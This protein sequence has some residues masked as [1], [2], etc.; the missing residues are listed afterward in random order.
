M[1]KIRSHTSEHPNFFCIWIYCEQCSKS[2]ILRLLKQLC[3]EIC[4]F[5]DQIKTSSLDLENVEF[6]L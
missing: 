1:P 3:D 2:V 5:N 4:P 6:T